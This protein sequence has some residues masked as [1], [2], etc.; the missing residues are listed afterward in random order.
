MEYIDYIHGDLLILIPL[1]III[2]KGFKSLLYC[3]NKYIPLILGIFGIVLA[4]L[5]IL[6]DMDFNADINWF[7]A[8]FTGIS[9]GILC[10]G[11]SVYGHQIIKQLSKEHK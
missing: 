6:S 2:G 3:D 8:V 9:Q 11:A 4:M 7:A 5:R 10:A 1:L